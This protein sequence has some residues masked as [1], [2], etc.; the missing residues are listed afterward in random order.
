MEIAIQ[1]TNY[2]SLPPRLGCRKNLVLDT[3]RET[4]ALFHQHWQAEKANLSLATEVAQAVE[5]H[6]KK[7]PIA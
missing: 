3:A 5:T 6:L 2:L 1:R 4:V 7:L